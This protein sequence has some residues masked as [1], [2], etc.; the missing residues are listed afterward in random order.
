MQ[1][2]SI[3][4]QTAGLVDLQKAAA[5]RKAVNGEHL[6]PGRDVSKLRKRWQQSND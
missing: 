5:R 4:A 6:P 3:T 1:R 2:G